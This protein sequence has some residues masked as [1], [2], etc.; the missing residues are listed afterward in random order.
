MKWLI[1]IISTNNQVPFNSSEINLS[2]KEILS[3]NLYYVSG[4][5]TKETI[6][7]SINLLFKDKI[8]EKHKIYKM[9]SNNNKKKK[10]LNK[11][12]NLWE[13]EVFYKKEVTDPD[14]SYI[15]K[16]LKDIKINADNVRTGYRYVVKGNLSY[17]EIESFSKRYLANVV[18]QDMYIKNLN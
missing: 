10:T 2:V 17:N 1:E 13:V 9:P 4:N 6:N 14:T 8:V 5:L 18:I 11:K 7:K 3:S 12:S 16:A 15:L